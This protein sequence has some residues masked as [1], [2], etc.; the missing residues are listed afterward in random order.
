MIHIKFFLPNSNQTVIVP[1]Q[2]FDVGKD[3]AQVVISGA[4]KRVQVKKDDLCDE[5]GEPIEWESYLQ[6]RKQ[7]FEW[8]LHEFGDDN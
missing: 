2:C 8:F 4:N 5:H 6:S 3:S 1:C 7:A